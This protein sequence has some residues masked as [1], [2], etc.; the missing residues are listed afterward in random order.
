VNFEKGILPAGV[1]IGALKSATGVKQ[2]KL[3]LTN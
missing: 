1:Y 2:Q 3:V